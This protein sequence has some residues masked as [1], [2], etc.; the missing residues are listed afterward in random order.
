MRIRNGFV[1]NSSSSSFVVIIPKNFEL[2]KIDYETLDEFSV[3]EEDVIN[4][5]NRLKNGDMIFEEDDDG[6]FNILED[7]LSD[8]ILHE[9]STSG[10]EG[11]IEMADI[12]KVKELL[13]NA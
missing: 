5:F 8:F 1:S 2:P 9:F 6:V 12:Q 7:I 4:A 13:K 3:N 11:F 10:G